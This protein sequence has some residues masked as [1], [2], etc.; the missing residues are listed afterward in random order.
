MVV[1]YTSV[2][3]LLGAA[4][5]LIKRRA[6]RLERKYSAVLKET[7]ALLHNP[8]KEGNSNRPDPFQSAKRTY[9]LGAMADKKERLEVR[10]Y[11]W[12]HRAEKVGNLL[13]RLRAWKGRKLPYVFGIVDSVVALCVLERLGYGQYTNPRRLLEMVTTWISG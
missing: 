5:F 8:P 2:L 4:H 13:T 12:Q 7:H 11:A 1:L 6:A 10:H 9:L 3:V